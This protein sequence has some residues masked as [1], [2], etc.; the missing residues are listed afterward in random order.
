[1]IDLYTYAVNKSAVG[2]EKVDI[3]IP[4]ATKR[5]AYWNEYNPLHA[6]F[7]E[8]YHEKGG[9]G[10][11]WNTTV[12]VNED[13]LDKLEYRLKNNEPVAA[14]E[15]V[16]IEYFEDYYVDEKKQKLEMFKF[17]ELTREKLKQDYIILFR[18]CW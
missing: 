18:S 4:E 6:F 12:S 1:M 2:S 15:C 10:L 7:V 13:D 5:I 3:P 17:I 11:F 9:Q 16:W 14:Y 8:L